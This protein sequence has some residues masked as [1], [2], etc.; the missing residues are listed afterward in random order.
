MQNLLSMD[1][2]AIK[3]E[4][5]K[6]H[7]LQQ[8]III[9][10]VLAISALIVPRASTNMRMF[11]IMLPPG[12]AIAIVF[13][14]YTHW[15]VLAMIPAS[16]LVPLAISTGTQT[17]INASVVLVAALFGFWILAMVVQQRFWLHPSYCWLPLLLF[18]LMAV[19]AF[20][21]GQQ[22]FL[23]M[24]GAPTFSQIGG[25]ALFL[26][27]AAAVVVTAHQLQEQIWLERLVWL[28]L[29][30][31]FP[32]LITYIVPFSGWLSALYVYRSFGSLYWVWMVAL[33]SG[34]ALFNTSL[35]WRWRGAL[36][37][38]AI[39]TLIVGIRNFGWKSGWVPSLVALLTILMLGRSWWRL[40]LLGFTGLA[41]APTV[42]SI[43][44]GLI[45]TESYSYLTRILAWQ[46]VLKIVETSP[47][48]GFGPAN[49][50]FYTMI[51]PILGYR[52]RFNSHNQYVD[53]I[54]QTGF[55]G[56]ICY[57]AVL[58]VF[59]HLGWRLFTRLEPGF[60]RGYAAGVLGGLAGMVATGFLGDWVIPF[61]YNVGFDGFRISILG[62]LF[63]GG[64]IAL[65]YF[66]RGSSEQMQTSTE[67]ETTQHTPLSSPVARR[68]T[69]EVES[70]ETP[71]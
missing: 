3:R 10:A 70:R 71:R 22:G 59:A 50:H 17:E 61:V 48:L 37:A 68:A 45:D 26:L 32:Y 35:R 27:S 20:I 8:A 24:S 62:W 46:I 5:I 51:M 34:Q 29:I 30:L 69:R 54:A 60:G 7:W 9:G 53:V 4:V 47:L 12:V 63:L 58:V 43:V 2:A 14:K 36:A 55:F 39:I 67:V 19:L 57:I 44:Q 38:V 31:G 21:N 56:L 25:L 64:L 49:Y 11:L 23:G 41:I 65:D 52:V 66:S 16:L 33:A 40:W 42:A 1:V 6:Q 15:G 28:F 13:L 18:A